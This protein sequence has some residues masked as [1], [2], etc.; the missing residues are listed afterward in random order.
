MYINTTSFLPL[1]QKTIYED[2][3][4]T[5]YSNIFLWWRFNGVNKPI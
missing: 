2:S 4:H 5:T 3:V 1:E